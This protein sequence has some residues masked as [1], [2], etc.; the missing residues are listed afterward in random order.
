[1]TWC[2]RG[3]GGGGDDGDS[4]PYWMIGSHHDG[5]HQ[6]YEESLSGNPQGVYGSG[7]VYVVSNEDT[8]WGGGGSNGGYDRRSKFV[9]NLGTCNIWLR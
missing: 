2:F 5:L 4:G 7:G 1:M 6:H 8:G 9:D 3:T